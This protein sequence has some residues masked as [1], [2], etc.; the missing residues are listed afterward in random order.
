MACQLAAR[1]GGS[2]IRRHPGQ[3]SRPPG[4]RSRVPRKAIAIE[5][6]YGVGTAQV[7]LTILVGDRQ[8]GSSMVFLDDELIANGDI[9]ELPIG[10][11]G[12]LS[13]RTATVYTVV[14]DIRDKHNEMSV[15]WILTGGR[16]QVTIEKTGSAAKSFGSQMFKA[17]FEFTNGQ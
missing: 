4:N 13:G 14:T 17:V 2:Y 7:R 5:H 12:D 9:D 8:Y 15:T 11:G 10:R 3:A 1:D 16:K 6:E